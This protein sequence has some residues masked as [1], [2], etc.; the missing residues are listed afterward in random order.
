MTGSRPL[1]T[2]PFRYL[3][4]A[5]MSV[6]RRGRSCSSGRR[7][8]NS[9]DGQSHDFTQS[10]FDASAIIRV[11]LEELFCV[12]PALAEPLAL[13]REP[14]AAL[15]DDVL[16]DGE[17]KQVAFARNALAVHDVEFGF[18]EGRRDLVL[19]DLGFCAAAGDFFTI[20]DGSDAP[21]VYAHRGV[22]LQGATAGGC[23]GVAE[24]DADLFAD[25]VD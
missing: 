24:H 3:R 21:H 5:F 15:F 18:P 13:E 1:G 16:V 10:E 22:E 17:I 23:F 2:T 12:I 9:G 20:L 8:R 11:V 4:A 7:G 14:C 19:D 25:L 6:V